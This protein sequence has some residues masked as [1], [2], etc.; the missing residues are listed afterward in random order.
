M[1]NVEGLVNWIILFFVVLVIMLNFS[2]CVFKYILMGNYDSVKVIVIVDG[3]IDIMIIC[4]VCDG[5]DG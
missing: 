3:V 5:Y 4:K 1:Q 2:E